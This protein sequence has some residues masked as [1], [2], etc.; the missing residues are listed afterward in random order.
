MG[1]E[2]TVV[3]HVTI[4]ENGQP[5][6]VEVVKSAGY[7]FDEEAVKAVKNSRFVP[8]RKESKPI[9]CKAV[10]PIR[11]VLKDSDHGW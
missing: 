5:V 7:G 1:R 9:V 11:F 8:A 2:G 10:L 4:D 3:L 6:L